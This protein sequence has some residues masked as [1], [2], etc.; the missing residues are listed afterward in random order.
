M[1]FKRLKPRE[2]FH[3]NHPILFEG[4]WMLGL[5]DPEVQISVFNITEE[6]KKFK[7]HNFPDS[8]SGGVSYEKVRDE[9]EKDLKITDFTATDLQDDIT[10]QLF[11][12][13]IEIN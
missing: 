4:S 3:F 10:H 13:N 12:R 8:K 11:L 6:N 7:L 9:I 1:E 2:T 5:T